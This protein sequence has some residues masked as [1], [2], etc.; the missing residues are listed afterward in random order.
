M[1]VPLCKQHLTEW[2]P[3]YL[4]LKFNDW[5]KKEVVNNRGS[6]YSRMDLVIN[7][8]NKDGGAHIDPALP[9]E[10]YSIK[11]SELSLIVDGMETRFDR[12]IVYA[13]VAQIGWELLNSIDRS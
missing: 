6:S 8:A 11:N 4:R 9:S 10:Y 13:S 7:V 5:W 1:A 3:G 12:N 2:Y